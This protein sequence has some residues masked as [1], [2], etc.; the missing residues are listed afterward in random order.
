MAEDRFSI[1]K[2]FENFAELGA[3]W[4]MWLM[5]LLGFGM[6][7]L[8]VERL[9]LFLRTQV[10]A[11]LIARQ[12]AQLLDEGKPEEALSLVRISLMTLTCSVIVQ[13]RTYMESKTFPTNIYTQQEETLAS[14]S[15]K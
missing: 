5:L 7:I 2:A 13:P 1:I 3:E 9:L 12:L 4:V 15:Q 6:L 10:D 8:L 11:P 14:G